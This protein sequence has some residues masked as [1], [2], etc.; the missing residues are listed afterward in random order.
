LPITKS[1]SEKEI[2]AAPAPR[3]KVPPQSRKELI[4]LV[5]ASILVS[6]GLTLVYFAKT[7]SFAD[8]ETRLNHGDLLNLNAVRSPEQLQP[9]F[10]FFPN[11]SEREDLAAKTYA[12]LERARPLPNVG[13]LARLR[14]P[15]EPGSK[16]RRPLLPVARLKP[17]AVVRTPLEFRIEFLKWCGIYLSAFYVVLLLWRARQF[18]PDPA[19]LPALHLL[20]GIGLILMV[21]LRDPLRDTLEF[22]KFA[23]GAALGCGILLLPMLR[24]F[25]YK[26]FA[27]WVYT[28]LWT[29]LALFALLERFGY[30][31]AGNDAKVN[32]GPFQP[33]EFIKILI[34]MFL[35]GYFAAKWERLRDLRQKRVNLP[36]FRHVLPVV[37]AVGIALAMFFL[38]KDLGP[39]LVTC[40]LFLAMFAVARGRAGL[41]LAAVALMVAGVAVGY[42]L[43]K[44]PTVVERIDMWTS[45]WDNDVRGGNQLA[46]SIWALSTGGPFGSGPGWGDPAMI[47][48][49]NNDLVLPAIGEEWGFA[50][51]VAVFLLFALLVRRA[52]RIALRAPTDH[53]FFLSIGL[54]CLIAMEM[55][56]ISGGVLGAI[57]L[58]GVV[59]PFL[60][61]G[62]T[63][64]LANFFVFAIL[65]SISHHAKEETDLDEHF[66]A[67]VRRL[68]WSLVLCGLTLVGF[69][70]RYQVLHDQEFIAR[71]AHVFEDDGV[72]RAQRNPRINSIAHEIE[73]G[74]IF[75]RNG[76]LLATSDWNELE[77][78]RGEFEKFGVAIDQACSR[79]DNRQYP[80]GS[81]TAHLL[82]DL[83][84]GENFH[85]TNASLIEH[86][87]N[88]TLQGY[89]DWHEL[90]PIVRYRHEPGNPA[91]EA[92]RH[93]D[94]DVHTS[95]DIRLEMSAAEIL[96][97]HLSKEG[98]DKGALV[99]L[100]P[101]TGDVL[102]MVSRPA[103]PVATATA[104]TAQPTP[105][106]LLDR[107]RYGQYPPGSTFKLVTAMAALRLDPDLKRK[108]FRCQGLGDGRVGAWVKGWN[109][110]IR[111]DIK[112]HA[113]GTLQ[114]QQA[115]TV[116]CNAYFAQLGVYSV[117]SQALDETVRMLEIPD[118]T[119]KELRH[120][121][122]F[123]AYGQGPLLITPFKM[124]RV[125]ATVAA[126]GRMPQGRWVT[127]QGNSRNDGPREVVSAESAAFLAGSMRS[128]VT[129]GTGRAAMQ[130]EAMPVAGKTGTAQLGA[131]EPHSWFAGFAPYGAAPK[132]IAFAVVVEHGGYG[133][134]VAAPIARELVDAAQRL[135][136]IG[137]P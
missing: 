5:A 32:L 4:W 35:A 126:G 102:A 10:R 38:A 108:T 53:A 101:E 14:A 44:P 3:P 19:I 70:A 121:L 94:R 36:R 40:F 39:A 52:F 132:R 96:D 61:S 73:R 17:L 59:S 80:F 123:A 56:L 30:G 37:C 105:E 58:S 29:A 86:D 83:R 111:D 43:G 128:V 28:P 72:K 133:G 76:V 118:G 113:H 109:R 88:V 12:F 63:A 31:P 129:S 48:A 62:N 26:R 71:E 23:W 60:S 134:R 92:L 33:V 114:M 27:E 84:T 64:M 49:G 9:F 112:D 125:A 51:V 131:G 2:R 21:S 127:G 74:N 135:E 11:P 85:A 137:I 106:Q 68:G 1:W 100:D 46:H 69:A 136:I 78:H 65:L 25:S 110:P 97:R 22:T 90:V 91:L 54:A 87:D 50:G 104:R 66:R 41:S 117:G 8:A 119:I 13:A 98:L 15:A 89:A 16:R 93:R 55:L 75:D 130:G 6:A 115:I 45:P 42:H 18:R 95:I 81:L 122:P 77:K 7:E 99:V 107:A 24:L 103:P 82:G 57:P 20:T 67:P 79:L 34:V 124:A 116:S 47:P 120:D